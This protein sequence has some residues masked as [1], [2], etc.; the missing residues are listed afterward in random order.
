MPKKSVLEALNSSDL[1][2]YIASKIKKVEK[3][4][5]FEFKLPPHINDAETTLDSYY[6]STTQ[7]DKLAVFKFNS[8]SKTLNPELNTQF[9]SL[10]EINKKEPVLSIND[11]FKNF[12]PH[13]QQKQFEPPIKVHKIQKEVKLRDFENFD[14]M[15]ETELDSIGLQF[16]Q[17]LYMIQPTNKSSILYRLQMSHNSNFDGSDYTETMLQVMQD[18]YQLPNHPTFKRFNIDDKEKIMTNQPYDELFIWSLLLYSGSKEDLR[19]PRFFWSKSKFPIACCL[20]AIIIYQNLKSE[21]LIPDYLKEEMD[22]AIK[23]LI[24]G[25]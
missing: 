15:T 11:S 9:K 21:S 12:I 2:T 4:D 8:K 16:L 3:S 5:S 19:L 7:S 20:A 18:C 13:K 22:L 17:K 1:T 24:F 23:Y 14:R 6:K 10:S 25:F